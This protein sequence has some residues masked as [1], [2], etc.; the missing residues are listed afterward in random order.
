[1]RPILVLVCCLAVSACASTS[2][3]KLPIC[4]GKHRRPANPYGSVL[5]P[6]DE[7]TPPAAPKAPDKVSALQS[8]V[9]SCA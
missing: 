8:R 4:G 7:A 9:G 6:K 2:D 3:G 1:M 5:A